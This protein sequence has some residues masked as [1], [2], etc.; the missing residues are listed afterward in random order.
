LP[1]NS[2]WSLNNK[3][4]VADPKKSA[5]YWNYKTK[6]V[7]AGR[8]EIW[9]W[10]CV[11]SISGIF[12]CTT[13]K[14]VDCTLILIQP[15]ALQI[16]IFFPDLCLSPKVTEIHVK[17]SLC[18][19]FYITILLITWILNKSLFKTLSLHMAA[20]KCLPQQLVNETK[21]LA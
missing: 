17:L 5:K 3:T 2:I 9:V 13:A 18:L 11:S 19:G 12:V 1:T 15:A 16:L 6:K 4:H 21:E 7:K 20:K 14:R 10:A 8:D